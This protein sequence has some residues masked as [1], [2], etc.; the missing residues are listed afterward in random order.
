MADILTQAVTNRRI[1]ERADADTLRRI[2]AAYQAIY[3]RLQGDIQALADILDAGKPLTEGQ[4]VRLDRYKQLLDDTAYEMERYGQYLTVELSS[5]ARTALALGE[6]HAR[7][8]IAAS[9]GLLSAKFQALNP[10]AIEALVDFLDPKGKLFATLPEKLGAWTK[11]N[12]ADAIIEFVGVGKNPTA[13]ARHLR[14]VYGYSLESSLTTARTVQ[15]YAYREANRA[16]Y[17][18]N[19]DIVGGW[20]WMSALTPNTCMA[21][22]R[23]HGTWHPNTERLNDHHRG[24]CTM[25][26]AIGGQ[27]EFE[28]SGENWKNAQGKRH[29]AG[30]GSTTIDGT[31]KT[32]EEWF[33]RLPEAHQ[34]RMMGETKFDAWKAGKFSFDSLATEREDSVYGW[35]KAVTP[36]KELIGQ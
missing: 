29:A 5:S 24:Y 36:L 2:V 27:T 9:T 33:A 25:L 32:G 20:F 30:W 12:V 8:L 26:P 6:Q 16:S 11:Q 17:L 3:T 19:S 28:F 10:G 14:K 23:M 34:R 13:L 4:L 1:I 22:V 18:A 31:Y 15:L 21:C 7:E 35:M